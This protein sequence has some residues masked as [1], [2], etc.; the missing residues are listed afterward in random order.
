MNQV[1]LSCGIP[2]SWTTF[3]PFSSPMVYCNS[4]YWIDFS[5]SDF[6]RF[7]LSQLL[8]FLYNC[9]SLELLSTVFKTT[10]VNWINCI[11]INHSHSTNTELVCVGGSFWLHWVLQVDS[12]TIQNQSGVPE[13]NVIWLS[14]VSGPWYL[15]LFLFPKEVNE[16]LQFLCLGPKSCFLF[17]RYDTFDDWVKFFQLGSKRKSWRWPLPLRRVVI[18]QV[19]ANTVATVCNVVNAFAAGILLFP[20]VEQQRLGISM[21]PW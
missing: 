16:H 1:N 12:Q 18:Q 14:S 4:S 8:Y 6:D 13:V 21:V 5:K 2:R 15:K 20:R 9:G 11:K 19:L 10:M 7:S 3:T 17:L